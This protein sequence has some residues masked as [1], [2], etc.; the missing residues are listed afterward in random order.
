MIAG[1]GYDA[2]IGSKIS[3]NFLVFIF[4]DLPLNTFTAV[5]IALW[6]LCLFK[7]DTKIIRHLTV[8]YK[9]LDVENEYFNKSEK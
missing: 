3:F 9:K 2:I 1:G 8:K 6:I 7:V 4:S 5:S